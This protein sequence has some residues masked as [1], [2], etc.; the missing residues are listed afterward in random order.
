MLK[1][2]HKAEYYKQSITAFHP[3]CL[4]SVHHDI[5]K[6]EGE[7]SQVYHMKKNICRYNPILKGF[8]LTHI[9]L[10]GLLK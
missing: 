3:G 6:I 5:L 1:S 2:S 7:R 4:F 10:M 9:H 8:A